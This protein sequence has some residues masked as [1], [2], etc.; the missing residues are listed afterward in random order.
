MK[1]EIKSV[2]IIRL[3][4]GM[5]RIVLNT[6]LPQGSHPFEGNESVLMFIAC[7]AAE[8]YC[9]KNFPDIEVRVIQA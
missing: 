7:G 6:D 9:K 5:D 1:I 3:G 8:E 2:E 4:Y